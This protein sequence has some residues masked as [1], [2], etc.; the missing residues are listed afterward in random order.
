MYQCNGRMPVSCLLEPESSQGHIAAKNLIINITYIIII[1][2]ITS[3]SVLVVAVTV[4]V[5]VIA[6]SSDCLLTR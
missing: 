1:N 5:V 4:A 6:L 3:I 2:N